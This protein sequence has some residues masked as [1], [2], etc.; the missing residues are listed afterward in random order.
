MFDKSSPLKGQRGQRA[1]V[2]CNIKLQQTM[3]SKKQNKT[4]FIKVAHLANV[5]GKQTGNT[6]VYLS[7]RI[8]ATKQ[9]LLFLLNLC[10]I[11]SERKVAHF[12]NKDKFTVNHIQIKHF[13]RLHQKQPVK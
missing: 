8:T 3:K 7:R 1:N 11:W 13:K 5:K 2:N 9:M 4:P 6:T 10:I 12:D